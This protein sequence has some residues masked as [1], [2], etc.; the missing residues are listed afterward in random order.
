[1]KFAAAALIA[2]TAVSG[3]ALT[4]KQA[5]SYSVTEFS[6]NCIPHSVSCN[7]HFEVMASSGA[8]SPVT[9][10]V[11]LQGPDSLPAV[12][13]SA[14]SSPSYS[15]SVVKAASGLD[16]TITTPLGAS[17]NVTGTHHIDAADIAS[18]QSGA[19]TTQSYTGSPSFTVPASVAQF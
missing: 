3:A 18:T 14:C 17:S 4:K 11:T 10:D 13:L 5:D 6:A 9:C 16:L 8:S 1:M 15:F 19:V 2:A 7:Y 12:P